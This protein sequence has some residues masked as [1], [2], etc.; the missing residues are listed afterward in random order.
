MKSLMRIYTQGNLSSKYSKAL[1]PPNRKHSSCLGLWA[2]T[3]QFPS[4]EAP[5]FHGQTDTWSR[6]LSASHRA[7]AC[8]EASERARVCDLTS[9]EKERKGFCFL[10]NTPLSAVLGWS[11]YQE[12]RWKCN[13]IIALVRECVAFTL[14]KVKY[15]EKMYYSSHLDYILL[16]WSFPSLLP[17]H[18]K[19]CY[20]FVQHSKL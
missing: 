17:T 16:L 15:R 11:G 3:V 19:H 2:E 13:L 18:F 8:T 14:E 4:H 9:Q 20:R 6:M 5:W 10:K 7:W 1:I 12:L